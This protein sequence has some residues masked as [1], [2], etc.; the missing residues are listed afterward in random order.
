MVVKCSILFL[1]E[2]CTAVW[3][4]NHDLEQSCPS[5]THSRLT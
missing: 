3:E 1:E 5:S 4:K 2:E